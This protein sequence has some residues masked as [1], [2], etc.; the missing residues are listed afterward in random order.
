MLINAFSHLEFGLPQH[1]YLRLPKVALPFFNTED[2]NFTQTES[3]E[4]GDILGY[5]ILKF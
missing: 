4:G 1:K 2:P 5:V 3:L